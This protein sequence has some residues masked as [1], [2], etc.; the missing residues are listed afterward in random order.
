MWSSASSAYDCVP[1]IKD[2]GADIVVNPLWE[3]GLGGS[4]RLGVER[5]EAAGAASVLLLLADQPCL[6]SEVIK[7]FRSPGQWTNGYHHFRP[8]PGGSW[9]ADDV[10][11]GLVS[12]IENLEGDIE[13]RATWSR[14][15]E[16]NRGDHSVQGAIDVDTAE[17]LATLRREVEDGD[18]SSRVAGVAGVQNGSRRG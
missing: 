17:D 11:R 13:E 14:K 8:L 4:I 15:K 5:A 7:R 6:N 10:R 2:C 9:C 3:S 16:L 1:I 18:R 12:A